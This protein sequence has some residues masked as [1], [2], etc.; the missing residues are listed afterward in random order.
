MGSGAEVQHETRDTCAQ[1]ACRAGSANVLV[2]WSKACRGHLS[3]PGTIPLQSFL[4]CSAGEGDG[5]RVELTMT[6]ALMR[7]MLSAILRSGMQ[8]ES[9]GRLGWLKWNAT[10]IRRQTR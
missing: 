8:R 5:R 4:A 7:K 10:R 3:T 9:G 1:R 6:R 2:R